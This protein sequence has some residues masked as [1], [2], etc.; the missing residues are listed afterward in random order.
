MKRRALTW[1]ST[2]LIFIDETFFS[3]EAISQ[4]MNGF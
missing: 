1:P 2:A 4:I 3:L